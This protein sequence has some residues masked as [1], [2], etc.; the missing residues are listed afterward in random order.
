MRTKV[1]VLIIGAKGAVATTLMA[2]QA[3]QRVGLDLNFMLPSDAEPDFAGLPLV[4]MDDIVYGGWDVVADSYV[5][6][7]AIHN[8]VPPHILDKIKEQMD[9]IP[10]YP[11]ILAEHDPAID[12]LLAKENAPARMKDV[13]Y[14]TTVFSK[15]PLNELIKSLTYDIEDFREQTGARRIIVVNLSSTER[16]SPIADCHNTLQSFEAAIATD[17]P[18]VTTGMIYAYAALK[19]GCHFVNFTPSTATDIAALEEFAN[20]QGVTVSGKDG[21]TGQT[22]YKTV[23]APMLR[24]RGLKLTGWY[25]TNILGNRDGQILNDPTHVTTKITS[26]SSV[27][28]SIMGYAD[29]DHQVHIHYYRPRGDSKEAWDNV[30]FKG[31][32]DVP[33][34][35]KIDWLGDDSILAAPLVFDLIRWTDFFAEKGEKGPLAQLAVYFKSPIATDECDFFKQLHMLHQHVSQRYL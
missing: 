31:W 33:M 17:D 4:G 16:P 27:L 9:A 34:Q 18:N 35:M 6:S 2:A 29:F 15:R 12:G 7:C 32:F 14:S 24:Y 11:A 1:G 13:D 5:D 20:K 26:K 8:V 10:S 28:S 3:A 23:L 21:K 25:S 19:N 30:D 22:L